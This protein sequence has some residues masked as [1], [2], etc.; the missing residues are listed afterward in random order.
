MRN[1]YPY[2]QDFFLHIRFSLSECMLFAKSTNEAQKP[3]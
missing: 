1:A 3:L 2:N